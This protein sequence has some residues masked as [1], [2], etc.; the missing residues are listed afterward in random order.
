MW[1]LSVRS[2]LGLLLGGPRRPPQAPAGPRGYWWGHDTV[3]EKEYR[4]RLEEDRKLVRWTRPGKDM[5][6]KQPYVYA[7]AR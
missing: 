5:Q 4:K 1:S 7:P 6:E 2:A 3:E